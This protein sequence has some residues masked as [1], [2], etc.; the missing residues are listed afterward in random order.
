[1]MPD[2]RALDRIAQ[3]LRA[4]D[5]PGAFATRRAMSADE[6][7]GVSGPVRNSSTAG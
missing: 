2:M 6:R 3:V 4:P 7:A 1:M 5:A